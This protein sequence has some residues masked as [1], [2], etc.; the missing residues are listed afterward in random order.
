MIALIFS[1]VCSIDHSLNT[2][3]YAN[4]VKELVAYE[5]EDSVGESDGSQP[6][7][8]NLYLKMDLINSSKKKVVE[9]YIIFIGSKLIK[10]K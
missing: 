10:F 6:G 4:S 3:R 2:L 5:F 9:S 7:T 8:D 1:S